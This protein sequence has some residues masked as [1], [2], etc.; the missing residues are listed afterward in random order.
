M[1]IRESFEFM[2]SYPIYEYS[3]IPNNM[4]AYLKGHHHEITFVFG[5]ES[6][7]L[8][9]KIILTPLHEYTIV[10]CTIWLYKP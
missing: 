2:V 7:L 5:R 4:L 3:V 6:L 8:G 9:I 1:R 10:F